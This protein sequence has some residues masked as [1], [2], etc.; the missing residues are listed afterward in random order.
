MKYN[1]S[2]GVKKMK[3][4]KFDECIRRIRS[5]AMQFEAEGKKNISEDLWVAVD[6][7]KRLQEQPKTD[8]IPC[9]KRLPELDEGTEYF[10]Q[11][12]PCLVA[13]EWW[14]GEISE[15]VGWY[16]QNGFWS[17]DSKN[18]KVIAWQPFQPYK[19]EGAEDA[20]KV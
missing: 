3:T 16:N 9:E 11:S 4:I 2:I 15:S 6:Y 7:L 14:D 13:L 8:W 1:L 18:C 19:K 20:E 10:K 5:Y 12:K 17:D